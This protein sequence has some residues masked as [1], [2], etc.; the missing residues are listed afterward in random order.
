MT[1]SPYWLDLGTREP[2]SEVGS[3]SF[4]SAFLREDL[5]EGDPWTQLVKRLKT[6]PGWKNLGDTAFER[7]FTSLEPVE[8]C[9]TVRRSDDY[10]DNKQ[11][12]GYVVMIKAHLS[13]H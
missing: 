9:V 8:L 5:L 13:S 10:A 2:A 7:C 6:A 3:Y 1:I 11:V 12:P 4:A